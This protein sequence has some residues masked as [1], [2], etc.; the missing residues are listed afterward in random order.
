MRTRVADVSTS[1]GPRPGATQP[2]CHSRRR[3]RRLALCLSR[4]PRG[5]IPLD[6]LSDRSRAA[7]SGANRVWVWRLWGWSIS[8]MWRVPVL[9]G[10]LESA[11]ASGPLRA[12]F[13]VMLRLQA[14][15]GT[16]KTALNDRLRHTGARTA[17]QPGSAFLWLHCSQ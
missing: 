7:H 11:W 14:P 3:V 9:I 13:E 1:A 16:S 10:S 4:S 2:G 12:P 15:F 8:T 5:G 17:A 6:R